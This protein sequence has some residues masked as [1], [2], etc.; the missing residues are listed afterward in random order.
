MQN[1]HVF[2]RPIFYFIIVFLGSLFLSSYIEKSNKSQK[3]YPIASQPLSGYIP[4][5]KMAPAT[6]NEIYSGIPLDK[7][8]I[9]QF[10]T[11]GSATAPVEVIWYEAD[12]MLSHGEDKAQNRLEP[13]VGTSA[14]TLG[15]TTPFIFSNNYLKV[16]TFK[17]FIKTLPSPD[18]E[19]LQ[20]TPQFWKDPKDGTATTNI[21]FRIKAVY[22]V[23]K[24][25]EAGVIVAE[26]FRDTDNVMFDEG[27]DSNPSPP[28]DPSYN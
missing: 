26:N 6:V 16:K 22:T 13:I 21:H 23:K 7:I 1:Q 11:T 9:F 15:E 24:L 19:Y 28:A 8:L 27:L 25:R 20:F 18:Y 2:R 12:G 5:F 4:L 17:D 3:L 14:I 10:I